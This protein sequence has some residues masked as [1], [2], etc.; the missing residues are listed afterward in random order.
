MYRP[1]C[2]NIRTDWDYGNNKQSIWTAE[3]VGHMGKRI[4]FILQPSVDYKVT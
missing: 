1:K 3:R 4:S 2:L